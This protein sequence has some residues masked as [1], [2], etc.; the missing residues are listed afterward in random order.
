MPVVSEQRLFSAVCEKPGQLGTSQPFDSGC[1][2][3][4]IEGRRYSL[5][6]SPLMRRFY[7]CPNTGLRVQSYACIKTS[8]GAYEVVVCTICR[9]VHLI[10]PATGKV[11]G[12]DQGAKVSE[13]V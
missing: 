3:L 6:M 9:G 12:E 4:G 10:D 8:D 11:L 7:R 13:T 5:M 1:H 2:Y